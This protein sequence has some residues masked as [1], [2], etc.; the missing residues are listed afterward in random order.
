ISGPAHLEGIHGLGD[1]NRAR[2]LAAFEIAR[3]YSR[4]RHQPATRTRV[5]WGLQ[6]QALQKIPRERRMDARE[7]L[8]FV[9][10][11]RSGQL[12]E[13]CVVE[14][15]VRTHVNVD[16][17]EFFAR[18]LAL[19]PQAFYLFHNHPSGTLEPSEPDLDLTRRVKH[20]AAVLGI[21]LQ[22]HA[23]VTAGLDCWIPM[24]F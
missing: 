7:W 5:G 10:L 9:P 19:R 20:S 14:H 6:N 22:G 21:R 1:A 2:I 13:L 15:G 18:L 12:G 4:H 8:G 16:P 23:I 24:D 17:V 11:Y 3:R